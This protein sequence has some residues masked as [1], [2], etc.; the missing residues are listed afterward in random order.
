MKE[1]N[2]NS[3]TQTVEQTT[4]EEANIMVADPEDYQK[5]RKFRAI[6]DAKE[7]VRKKRDDEPPTASTDEWKGIH[8]RTAEAVAIYG[9]E[10]LPLIEEGLEKGILNESDLDTKHGHIM[11]FIE[12]DGRFVDHEDEEVTSPKPYEY[13]AV[14]RQLQRIE[15]EL[16][17][18]PSL[19]E[20]QPPAEI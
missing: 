10:L 15:R 16:G 14:F 5:T 4:E 11:E 13:M 6:S 2:N 3:D 8:A 17:L 1:R 7:R 9:T 18:G 20:E 19:E 12:C